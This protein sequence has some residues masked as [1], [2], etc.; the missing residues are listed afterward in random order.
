MV[1]IR[2]SGSIGP[3]SVTFTVTIGAGLVPALLSPEGPYRK[4]LAT[5]LNPADCSNGRN[6]DQCRRGAPSEPILVSL[7]TSESSPTKSG[8]SANIIEFQAGKG[9]WVRGPPA[10]IWTL[11]L[12][13][14]TGDLSA[15][16]PTGRRIPARGA[17]P[18]RLVH[19]SGVLKERRI[20]PHQHKPGPI[21][22]RYANWK[23]AAFLQKP[24]WTVGQSSRGV[25]PCPLCY[26]T[27][28]SRLAA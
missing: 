24:L 2:R 23:Y 25:A 4:R 21:N 11:D 18:G 10:R 19:H 22:D 9:S 26:F 7:M 5:R 17:T 16:A 6:P 13:S 27:K 8:S 12:L 28:K 20:A 14:Q 1:G 3:P 15:S